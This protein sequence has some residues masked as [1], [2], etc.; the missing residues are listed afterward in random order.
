MTVLAQTNQ[1]TPT[2]D[3]QPPDKQAVYKLGAG[4]KVALFGALLTTRLWGTIAPITFFWGEHG[5]LEESGGAGFGWGGVH[6]VSKEEISRRRAGDGRGSGAAGVRVPGEVRKRAA[7][8]SRLFRS[9]YASDG[10]GGSGRQENYR[11]RRAKRGGRVGRDRRVAQV[12]KGLSPQSSQKNLI[13]FLCVLRYQRLFLR[14]SPKSETLLDPQLFSGVWTEPLRSPRGSP[15]YI[16]GAVRD[17]RQLLDARFHL[18]ADVDMLGAALRGEGHVHR[19]ILLRFFGIRSGCGRKVHVV[20]QAQIDDV[21]RNLRVVATL[22]RAQYVL[23]GN[24][25]RENSSAL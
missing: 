13:W 17:T 11:S 20:D 14:S 2:R 22:Q 8:A 23:F 25:H 9:R 19:D 5:E 4:A 16:H 18:R 24:G 12:R 10:D 3:M 7:V 15:H 1:R 21:D 6:S